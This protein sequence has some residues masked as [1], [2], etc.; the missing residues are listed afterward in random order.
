VFEAASDSAAQAAL[1]QMKQ[2]QDFA[3]IAQ[4]SSINPTAQNGGTIGWI[5]FKTPATEGQTNGL[6]LSLAQSIEKTKVGNVSSIVMVDNTWWIVKVEQIRKTQIQPFATLKEE[7]R[8]ALNSRAIDAAA[9]T[10]IKALSKQAKI[11]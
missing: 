8:N 5:T 1:K 11:Q 3:K 10:K 2:G 7:I 6:P 4:H 9:I